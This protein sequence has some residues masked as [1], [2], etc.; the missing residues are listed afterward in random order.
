[1]SLARLIAKF[2]GVAELPV[3]IPEVRD[4]IVALGFQDDI[5]FVPEN[6]DPGKLRGVIYRYTKRDG[7]YGEPKLCTLIVYSQNLPIEWQRVVCGKEPRSPRRTRR[8][9]HHMERCK[10]YSPSNLQV[11]SPS[12]SLNGAGKR[13]IWG[14]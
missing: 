3:E 1:M 13:P 6:I 9:A 8:V 11:A 7:V 2:A 12:Q 14:Q 4:A 5:V 10:G